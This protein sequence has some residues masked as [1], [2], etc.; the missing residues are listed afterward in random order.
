MIEIDLSNLSDFQANQI[1][2]MIIHRFISEDDE[3]ESG[4]YALKSKY[5]KQDITNIRI[6]S[7]RYICQ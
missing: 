3:V 2:G 4:I 6:Y 1:M 5:V 7:E